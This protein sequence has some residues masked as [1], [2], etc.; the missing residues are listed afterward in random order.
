[1]SSYWRYPTFPVARCCSSW[2]LMRLY[3]SSI[4]P[5]GRVSPLV[6]EYHPWWSSITPGG[7]VSPPCGQVSPLVVKYHPWWSSIT[8]GG[9]VSSVWHT[10]GQWSRRL[11]IE[12]RV[13]NVYR[14]GT[15]LLVLRMFIR[16][17]PSRELM[18]RNE[19]GLISGRQRA[20]SHYNVPHNR[21]T[22]FSSNN[23]V[24]IAIC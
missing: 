16:L 11:G 24:F 2:Q 21:S 18:R 12:C 6:V 7:Q 13:P 23:N 9:R 8:P 3:W 20:F 1:M 17:R 19:R 22:Y 4:T 5:G 15:C 14:N 10:V